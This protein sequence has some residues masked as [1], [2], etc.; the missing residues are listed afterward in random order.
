MQETLVSL[1]K[2]SSRIKRFVAAVEETN[3][4]IYIDEVQQI[5]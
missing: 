2:W 5:N 4:P 3:H 1:R